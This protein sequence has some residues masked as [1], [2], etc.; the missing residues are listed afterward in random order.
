[1]VPYT[2][3]HHVTQVILKWKTRYLVDL[4]RKSPDKSVGYVQ[5]P[6]VIIC[7]MY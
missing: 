3:L 1:M 6:Q 2:G 4:S 5:C 7:Q